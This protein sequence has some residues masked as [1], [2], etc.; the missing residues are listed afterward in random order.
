MGRLV[1]QTGSVGSD[2]TGRG[3]TSN[4]PYIDVLAE[5]SIP[6]VVKSF[7]PA[8]IDRNQLTRL[9]FSIYDGSSDTD[10][11]NISFT[12]LLP[13]GMQVAT[14]PDLTSNCGGLVSALPDGQVISVSGVNLSWGTGCNIALDVIASRS[15]NLFNI[16]SQVTS[17]PFGIG[18]ISN[19]AVL[20]VRCDPLF[21]T[22]RSNATDDCGTLRRALELAGTPGYGSDITFDPLMGD[23]PTISVNSGVTLPHLQRGVNL[24][25][26]CPDAERV[27]IYGAGAG[28]SGLVSGG[29]NHLRGLVIDGFTRPQLSIP[30]GAGGNRLECMQMGS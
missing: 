23:H 11:G 5:L 25:G 14:V 29:N 18:L 26:G 10:A 22:N 15:G 8:V 17:E 27:R 7:S 4:A 30:P 24:L 19:R 2:E 28:G 13:P 6:G 16:T 9:S 20:S 12:D 1:N 3:P 21:V